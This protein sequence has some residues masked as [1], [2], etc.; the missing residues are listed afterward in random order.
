ML[1]YRNKR[2]YRNKPLKANFLVFVGVP[3]DELLRYLSHLVPWQREAS[4]PKELL[5]LKVTDVTAVIIVC[6]RDR[7]M[8]REMEEKE[9]GRERNKEMDRDRSDGEGEK[10]RESKR[11]W[12]KRERKTEETKIET[13]RERERE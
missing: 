5:Q 9:R 13:E 7:E 11:R 4:F 6:K 10:V 2:P 3:G 12:M 8:Q 1:Q